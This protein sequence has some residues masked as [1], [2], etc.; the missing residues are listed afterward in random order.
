MLGGSEDDTKSAV[1]DVHESPDPSLV[2]DVEP[3]AEPVSATPLPSILAPRRPS[4]SIPPPVPSADR[5]KRVT[6]APKSVANPAEPPSVVDL[7][8]VAQTTI[9]YRSRAEQLAKEVEAIAV[10]DPVAAAQLSYELGELYERRLGLEEHAVKSYRR[11]FTLDA[12][13]RPNLWALRRVLYRRALWPEI[14]KLIDVEGNYATDDSERVDL[15]I[16]RAL[17]SGRQGGADEHARAALEAA[18]RITP[19][20]QGALLELERVIARAG[21]D[22]ALL[23][24]WESLATAIDDPEHK[25]A[26]WVDVA[27]ASAGRDHERARRAIDTAAQLASHSG[28]VVLARRVAR[29]RL[30]LV[31]VHGTP[32][33]VGAAIEALAHTLSGNESAKREE[34]VRLELVALRRRQAQLARVARPDEA[35]LTAAWGYLQQALALAPTEPVILVDLIELASELRR[36]QDLAELAR[37]FHAVP[38]N[39][40]GVSMLSLWC[41]DAHREPERRVA[42]R[43]LLASLEQ[44]A[45]G[46]VLLTASAECSALARPLDANALART[47]IASARAAARGTWLGPVAAPPDPEASAALLVQAAD[48][49]AYYVGTPAA[50]EQAREA[51]EEAARAAPDHP[52]VLEALTEL[53]AVAGRTE[54]AIERLRLQARGAVDQRPILERAIRLARS[55]AQSAAIPGLVIE[56]QREL[57]TAQPEDVALAW[58]LESMLFE[59]GRDGERAELLTRLATFDRDPE[60]RATAL[61][62]AAR[63]HERAGAT[64]AATDAYRKLRVL[65]PEDSFT[66]DALIGLLREQSRWAELVTERRAEAKLVEGPALR[67][68]LREASWLLEVRL[69]DLAGAAEVYDEWLAR[70]PGDR[71]AL[72]G[73]ARCRGQLG[74]HAREVTVRATIAEL[75]E[76]H[77]AQ[78]LYARSLERAGSFEQ[79]TEHYRGLVASEESP[80]ASTSASLALGDLAVRGPDMALRVEAA[81]SLANRTTDPRLGASLFEHTGWIHVIALADF[82]NAAKSFAAALAAEPAREGALLGAAL[83]AHSRSEPIRVGNA[84][85]TLA[86][87]LQMPEAAAALF[88]RAAAIAT[89]SGDLELANERVEAA[90][91]A[92]PDSVTAM[93]VATEAGPARASKSADPFAAVDRLLARAELIGMRGALTDDPAEIAAWELDRA[94]TLELAGQVREASEVFA[95]VLAKRPH[96]RRAVSALRRIANQAGDRKTWARACYSLA[97]LGRDPVSGLRLLRE[98]LEV[99][100]RPGAAKNPDYTLAI[101][102]RIVE[103]DPK[104]PEAER[105]LELLRERGD[106]KSL[107]RSLTER[108][109]S[110]ATNVSADDQRRDDG[111]D[112][113]VEAVMVPLLLERST[114][115]RALGR[116]D[117]AI[118]D[119]DA[120]LVHAPTN[121]DALRLRADLAIEAGDVDRAVALWWRYLAVETTTSRRAEI[122]RLLVHALK[123]DEGVAPPPSALRPP[124]LKAELKDELNWDPEPTEADAS[125]PAAIP[126]AMP[127]LART[128]ESAPS[129]MTSVKRLSPAIIRRTLP[130]VAATQVQP[131]QLD[132]LDANTVLTDLSDLQEQERR[133]AQSPPMLLED[134][135]LEITV[136]TPRPMPEQPKAIGTQPIA[137]QLAASEKVVPATRAVTSSI[138]AAFGASVQEATGPAPG[139][140]P[141]RKLRLPLLDVDRLVVGETVRG[142]GIEPLLGATSIEFPEE[143]ELSPDD[144]AVV[145]LSYE[146][147]QPT[148]A[149]EGT[150]EILRQ[151]EAEIAATED[152]ANTVTLRIEAGRLAERLRKPDRASEH[153]DAALLASPHAAGALRGLRR[154]ARSR[155]DIAEMTRLVEAEIAIASPRERDAL[156]RYRIDLLMA[157]GEQ[158]VARVAVGELLDSAPHDLSAL[159]AHLELSFLDAR[160]DEMVG[161]VEQVAQAITDPE[162]RGALQAARGVLAEHHGDSAAAARWF[163]A[164]SGTDPRSPASRLSAVRYQAAG[165]DADPAAA[166]LLELAYQ[167]EGEDPVTAAALAVRTQLWATTPAGR[168]TLAAAAQLAA[169]AAPR[170]PLVARIATETALAVGDVAIATHAFTRWARGKSAPVER[171]YAAARAAELDPTRLGRLWAQVLELDP[172]DDYA[173]AR[174]RAGHLAAGELEQVRKLDLE[175]VQREVPA[176][177]VAAELVARDQLEPAI[178]LLLRTRELRPASVAVGEALAEVF[179]LGKRWNE[180]AKLLAEL[181]AAGAP[182]SGAIARSRSALAWDQ[183]VAATASNAGGGGGDD[184]RGEL[185][186][187][188]VTALDAW[189][190]VL[191]D[192]PQS[193]VA[194]AATRV[195]ANRLQDRAILADVLARAQAAERSPWAA[196]SLALRHARLLLGNDARLAQDIARD[197]GEGIDDPRRT[198]AVMIAAAHRHELGEAATA[199]EDRAALLE[200]ATPAT[201]ATNEPATLRLRAAQLALDGDD[202]PRA[203]VLLARVD[204]AVPGIADDLIDVCGRR[205]GDAAITTRAR[206]ASDSFLRV[207][208]EADLATTRGELPAALALYR[209]ALELRPAHPLA[210]APLVRIASELHEPAAVTALALDQLRSAEATGDAIAKSEA[211]E[212]LARVERDTSAALIALESALR[213]DPSRIDLLHR[214]ERELTTAGRYSELVHLRERELERLKRAHGERPRPTRHLAAL[215]MDTTMLAVR[216]KRSDSELARLYRAALDAD[217]RARLAMFHL[218]SIL[219]R[220]GISE[221]LAAIEEQIADYFDDP[222]CKAAFLTRAGIT[223]AALGKPADAV[224][225][226]ARATA[227]LPGYRPALDGWLQTALEGRLWAEAARAAEHKAN[228][229][230]DPKT[231]AVL[232]HFAGVALM[233]KALA[234]EPAI[235]ALRRALVADPTH[236]DAFRRLR[237]LFETTAKHDEHAALLHQRLDVEP[238]PAA[239]AELHRALA[240][241]GFSVGDLRVALKH[242]RAVLAVDPADLRA[243]TAIADLATS[244]YV[245]GDQWRDAADAVIARLGLETEPRVQKTLHYR[246]GVIYGDH[247]VPKAIVELQRAL[248]FK[249]DDDAAL[250][251]LT[252]LAISAGEW[253]L[254]LDTCKQLVTAEH[255]PEQRAANLRRASLIFSQGFN[256]PQRA[257]RMLD[258]AFDEAPTVEGLHQLV[259]VYRSS[260]DATAMRVQLTRIATMMRARVVHDATNGPAYRMLAHAITESKATGSLPAA[261]AAAELAQLVGA[262]GELEQRL[263]SAPPVIDPSLW[264]GPASDDALFSDWLPADL[265]QVFRRFGD[266]IARHVGVDLNVHGVGRKDRLRAHDPVAAAA[267][268]IAMQLGLGDIDVYV[269]NRHP[270]AMVSEPTAPTSL[271]LG[272]AIVAGGAAGVRFAAGAALKLAQLSLAVPARLPHNDLGALGLA[273][274]R[275][276]QPELANPGINLDDVNAQMLKLRRL[277]SPILFNEVRPHALAVRRFEHQLIARDLKVAGLRAGFAISGNLVPGL[278]ILA[279]ASGIDL[280]AILADPVAQGLIT[281]ALTEHR[282]L[283]RSQ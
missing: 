227:A 120:L 81:D 79:A 30:R 95:G 136:D 113:A 258:L 185:E 137:T 271:I 246:L 60:R 107:I 50:F 94:E 97:R 161:A 25:I 242:Y 72:E 255:P 192:D 46:F 3:I 8:L 260:G 167:I 70:L 222:R 10:A 71:T 176:L 101:Y 215:V 68:A 118:A 37:A 116:A 234:S 174:V 257:Q 27:R 191:D 214:L 84:Y 77:D 219:R 249:P 240:E 87:A 267:R 153:Y 169:R 24:V 31:D 123:N 74:D 179:A 279:G 44:T 108:L 57:V 196:S 82:E 182:G 14:V 17:A 211:Y 36:D 148:K 1:G 100:A 115:L 9:D 51:L 266:L 134:Y 5:R 88:L 232:H 35:G 172:D 128:D 103:L 126:V 58:R 225:R 248:T 193:P 12:S 273:L 164:A 26:Y 256:D 237:T 228:V 98:A 254:A 138:A 147:L 7:A 105:L 139:S 204:Q 119:L 66:R 106:G 99:F 19:D 156:L 195:L 241:H 244:R 235:E 69:D 48:L 207:L 86:A 203:R 117:L 253:Q 59:V 209:L 166:A 233:D 96:D 229:A 261:R 272:S 122:E 265:R 78:W 216:A 39:A 130:S 159:L 52:V 62:G 149:D 102:R 251:R 206:R 43:A 67:P 150:G 41:A 162:L 18:L 194:H 144:S 91:M 208:R 177:R 131:A 64:A 29:E 259:Q 197:A 175:A 210:A 277:I 92:A 226:F 278:A 61:F 22:A 53:D 238:T 125:M 250:T 224:Q 152:P 155:G 190:L 252:D 20:H 15:L 217:A 56:L 275:L 178:E 181:A 6:V 110:L 32:E 49:L 274:L 220:A 186:R 114:L 4:R 63:L 213:A 28:Q 264:V 54:Q 218:E 200:A 276:F 202:A 230:G 283:G 16:E 129:V 42:L 143:H 124:E 157:T 104:A 121:L 231:I 140:P 76:T 93:L 212:L 109:S 180:R 184:K 201:S 89:A 188:I 142:D 268:D 154:L 55:H 239:K 145:M 165:G 47:Y 245:D 280:R 111:R 127:A 262:G 198:L 21:D 269:S 132:A 133:E 135:D 90:R 40:G 85:A 171:A 13:L 243:H 163:T 223:L 65:W 141:D 45:P 173:L 205:I 158:D 221:A 270:Y 168:E 236:F 80:V 281:F 83:V 34:D 75:D 187:A 11:A 73:I 146:Q 263:T 160:A 112:D 151:Y 170:D 2:D 183:A 282:G 38:G 23:D 33:Q 247:D 199:L 189:D